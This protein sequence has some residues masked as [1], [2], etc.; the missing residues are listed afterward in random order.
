MH[1]GNY[2]G[3]IRNFVALCNTNSN[4]K[5]FFIAD[6]H[7]L[8]THSDPKELVE[9][10][11]LTLAT[12]LGCGLDP[13]KAAIYFQSDLPQTAELYL[14]LNMF[15]NIGELERT[16][17]FKEKIEKH[18]HNINAGLL[19]YPVLMTADILIHKGTKVPVGKDQRQHLEMARTFAN[20]FNFNYQ[21][22]VFPEPLAFTFDEQLLNIPSL[23]GIGKMSKSD[24]ESSA[25]YVI[26]S[27][28]VIEKKIKRAKSDSGPTEMNSPIA[29]EIMHLFDLLKLFS[30]KETIEMYE[31]AYASCSIRYGDMKSQMAQDAIAFI[32]PIRERI[33]QYIAQP[34]LLQEIAHSGAEKAQKSANET[35]SEIREVMGLSSK[36]IFK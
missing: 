12:Y 1:I 24:D 13:E 11:K 29:A 22:N 17:T 20:R 25:L 4:P 9:N 2:F 6:L 7:S 8:T 30:S 5:Y 32:S 18:A 26:D 33:Q 36:N 15:A 23:T 19:T 35:L 10:N 27:D 34:K 14:Y 3:A 31:K 16:T 21:R 28:D